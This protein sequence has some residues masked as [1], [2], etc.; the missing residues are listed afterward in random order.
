RGIALQARNGENDV[1]AA[2]DDFSAAIQLEPKAYLAYYN[3]GLAYIRL[4]QQEWWMAD[5]EKALILAPAYWLS[6]HALC[7]GYAL[8][9]LPEEGIDHCDA[10]VSHDS[11][12]STREAR[13]LVLAELGQ[14]D[15][16]I[17]DLEQ[18]L[19]WLDTQPEAW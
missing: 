11:S 9:M 8:D 13:G 15:D 16:A 4:D 10:A 14:M 3:R 19:A 6:H 18:Y 12:G 17:A 5:L 1:Q 2:I 7:W